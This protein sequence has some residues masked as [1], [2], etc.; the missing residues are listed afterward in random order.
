M[1]ESWL[2]LDPGKHGDALLARAVRL[3]SPS[4]LCSPVPRHP[5]RDRYYTMARRFHVRQLMKGRS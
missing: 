5:G 1:V 4:S 2:Y 3:G